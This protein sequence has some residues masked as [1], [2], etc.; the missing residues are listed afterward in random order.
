MQPTLFETESPQYDADKT[1]THG[2]IF[3]L[4]HSIKSNVNVKD[5]QWQYLEGDGDFRSKEVC[6]LR[7][8]A[9]IIITNPPF[10][11][12]RAFFSWIQEANKQFLIISGINNITYKEVF[13]SIMQNK[14]WSG[15]G[16][17]RWISGFIVPDNYPLSG[18]EARIE[19]GKRIV[20]T[21][22]CMWLTNIEHGKRHE[23]LQLMTMADNLRYSKHEKIREQ[24][25]PKYDNY[26][27]I[28]VWFTD[29]IPSDYDGIMA[30]PITFLDKY[31]PEQFEIIGEANHGSDSEY[32]FVAPMLNG[33]PIFKRLLIRKRK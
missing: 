19:N 26:D 20:S 12:F 7:D 10:S 17:G 3:V 4:D 18:T 27:A 16:M 29:S 6:K 11:L 5:L 33:K 13:V 14:T 23:P 1:N 22:N 31:N 25:Y 15:H 28:H 32:D 9:D 2:K 24:G 21:N 30:V 8:E